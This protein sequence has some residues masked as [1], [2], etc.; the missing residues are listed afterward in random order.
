MESLFSESAHPDLFSR[1]DFLEQTS[2][3]RRPRSNREAWDVSTGA[4]LD[5]LRGH[6]SGVWTVAFSADGK[7]LASGGLDQTVKLWDLERQRPNDALKKVEQPF[8]WS[9]DSTMLASAHT[10]WT[11]KIWDSA[12]LKPHRILPG[13]SHVLA[14]S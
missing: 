5:T 7:Q 9:P 13:V 2:W 6:E 3:P 12:T 14:F 8:A 4:N 1:Q 11:A 10:N